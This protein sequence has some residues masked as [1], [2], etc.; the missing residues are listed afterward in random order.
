[1]SE[2]K[3]DEPVKP[4]PLADPKAWLERRHSSRWGGPEWW[5]R[6]KLRDIARRIEDL[7]R[8]VELMEMEESHGDRKA[9]ETHP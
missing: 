6:R 2:S 7:K 3:K 9:D 8:R 1:M 5:R 4:D